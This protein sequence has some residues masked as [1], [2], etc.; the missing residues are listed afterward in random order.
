M[1]TCNIKLVEQK[2]VQT[3]SIIRRI[4]VIIIVNTNHSG[5]QANR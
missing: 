2:A 4:S 5:V 1:L 3:R